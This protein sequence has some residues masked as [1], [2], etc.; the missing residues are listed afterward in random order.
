MWRG[1][2]LVVAGVLLVVL[3]FGGAWALAPDRTVVPAES[4]TDNEDVANTTVLIGVQGP[5]PRGNVTELNANA[6]VRWTYDNG[7]DGDAI[8]YQNVQQ[9]DDGRVLTTFAD[10]NY[11]NC[12]P[13]EQPCKRTGIRIIDPTPEPEVV[14]EWSYPMR[15]RKDSEVHDAE[16]LPS[17]DVLVADMEFESI[18]ILNLSTEERTWTWNASDHYDAPADPTK[19]DWLHINDVDYIGEERYLVSVR[20]ANQLVIVKRGE[21]VVEVINEDGDP[22][23]MNEQHNPQWLGDGRVLV[24]DSENNRVVELHRN[25]STAEWEVSWVVQRTGGMALD[26]PRDADRLPNGRTVITDSRNDRVVV[27]DENGTLVRSYGTTPLPYEADILPHGE[28]VAPGDSPLFGIESADT[29]LPR[30][31]PVLTTLLAAVRHVVPIPYWVSELHVLVVGVALSL[32]GWGGRLL[33][34]G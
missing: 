3:A 18:F 19:E 15:T 16:M 4:D 33:V 8:S 21:G 24:A 7:T 32:W 26:W 13:Y 34:R 11:Q 20:N 6:T 14:Y 9:L 25:E 30:K 29:V 10:D 12:G 5:G 22:A 1:L 2:A 27:V 17:G 23:V 28:Q 31:I